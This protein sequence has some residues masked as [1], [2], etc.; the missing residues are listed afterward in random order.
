M[1]KPFCGSRAACPSSREGFFSRA[2]VKAL[3]QAMVM[4]ARAAQQGD[5]LAVGIGYGNHRGLAS[6][7]QFGLDGVNGR[8]RVGVAEVGD[9]VHVNSF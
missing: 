4:E 8:L 7:L 5:Q 2:A 1:S 6:A 9:L 3:L